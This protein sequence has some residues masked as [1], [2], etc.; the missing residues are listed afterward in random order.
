MSEAKEVTA[1]FN[2]KTY[3]V[4]Y[5]ANG[6]TDGT[7]PINQS[8]THGV[9]LL[10]ATN[11][12]N[13]ENTGYTFAGWNTQADGGGT[14]YAVGSNYTNNETLVLYAKWILVTYIGGGFTHYGLI[15]KGIARLNSNGTLD[16]SFTVGT[17]AYG[18]MSVAVQS[19]GKV[20][21]GG[22]FH[23]YNDTFISRIAR[24]NS[25]GT[26]D[27]SFTVGTGAN[28]AVQSVAVQSDGKVLIGGEFTTYND[29]ARNRI[30]RLNSNGTLD[31]S[32]TVGTGANNT[33]WS[34]AVQS[35][36]KVLI[37]GQFTT[38]NDT[39]INRIARLNSDGTLDT[40]FTVG[41]GANNTVRSVA[42]QSDGKVLISGEFTTYNS[43]ARNRIVRLNSNGTL[44]TSF[45]IGTGASLTVHSVA[46]QSDGKVLIGGQFTTYNS[47]ARNRIARLNSNGTLDTSFTV[48]TGASSTVESVAVQSDGKVLIGGQF[49]TYN[50]TARNRIARLN[51]NGTLDTSFTVGTGANNIVWSVAV[52][53]D[54]KV[55]IG[56]SFT[57]YNSTAINRIARLN[58]NGTLDTS[59]TVGTGANNNVTSV[60][61][62]S[63]G[64]VLIGGEFTTYNSTAIN[65]IA[66]LNSDGTLDTSFTVGTGASSTVRSVAVQSD[67]KVLIGGDFTTYNST[68]INR[69]ARLNSNG[70][71]DTSFTVGTGA[72]N[73]VTSVAVQS[74]GK[75]LIGGSF[76]AYNDTAINRIARLNSNGTLDTSFTVGTGA[77]NNVTSVAVQSDGK[78]LIGGSFTAYNSTA[79]NRIAR[80]N[81]DGT[82][83]TS[84]T[85][86]TGAN[87]TVNSVAVQSDGKVLI[88]GSFTA[89]N[90]TARNRIA[91]LNSD[92]T[93]DTSFTI[94]I[95]ANS[96][97][98]SVAVQSD[99]KVL[100]GGHFTT[101]NG[102]ARNYI[103]RLNS[104]GTLDTSFYNITNTVF[105]EAVYSI[106]TTY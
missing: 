7:A 42:V 41:T 92:G 82:L 47:T 40:S 2:L 67:G 19:D 54:G 26:L 98:W 83:D 45:T 32:F 85:V 72:N 36:G 75:V 78:V 4:S 16:T 20:L 100:I 57:A 103:A 59:F 90:S 53:S 55:L 39:A 94:G 63:D 56:G 60:A 65:R 23:T 10:L 14:T 30:A 50:S 62:Q 38:Y 1:N 12:G 17:G 3:T 79:R 97:V 8:K 70:T 15:T 37:G 21:I 102:T 69:I 33:V 6:A 84:F 93:L 49:T 86:G 25:N 104:D 28:N 58:S 77:N 27:T 44:D 80:L 88:G 64:K 95:G 66:R 34:V 71:L 74:D 31:T 106:T 89:Y 11:S 43:T 81:S 96:T 24:L 61:V 5:N 22:Q 35:N 51:S 18:V 105:D 48:G 29:T 73:T 52:Q 91:R 68:A 76:T 13:L 99:G 87:N 46:V 9:N 101:Y